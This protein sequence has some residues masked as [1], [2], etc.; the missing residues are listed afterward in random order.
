MTG[1]WLLAATCLMCLVSTAAADTLRGQ[2]LEARTCD[3]YT[4]PC[5]ANAEIGLAGREAVLAWKVDSGDWRGTSLDGLCVAVVLKA[6]DTLGDDGVFPMAAERIRSVILVDERGDAAQRQALEGFARESASRYTAGV[7]Q[8]QAVPMSLSNDHDRGQGEFTAG[9]VAEV[10]TRAMGKLDCV[11]TNEMVFYQPLT[12]VKFASPV[13]ALTQ[14]YRGDG[15]NARWTL[16]ST[17]SA[18]LGTFKAE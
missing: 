7:E 9:N 17:R 2:Y 18:F 6:D 4:G 10:R 3:I 5:F 1:R 14:S 11:C 8:V 15:L 12:E 16:N 13:Y